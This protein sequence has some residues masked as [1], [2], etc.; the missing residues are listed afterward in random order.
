MP[1]SPVVGKSHTGDFDVQSPSVYSM[2][3]N[4]SSLFSP[5]K[6]LKP[7]PGLKRAL[8]SQNGTP[9]KN[10][11]FRQHSRQNNPL[12]EELQRETAIRNGMKDIAR[13]ERRLL[14]KRNLLGNA[15][16]VKL[17]RIARIERNR[18]LFAGQLSEK[19]AELKKVQT[20]EKEFLPEETSVVVEA[21]II[22]VEHRWTPFSKIVEFDKTNTSKETAPRYQPSLIFLESCNPH[23]WNMDSPFCSSRYRRKIG[24]GPQHFFDELNEE[25]ENKK[26]ITASGDGDT[27]SDNGSISSGIDSSASDSDDDTCTVTSSMMISR[28][29]SLKFVDDMFMVDVK[30]LQKSMSIQE[31]T[32]EGEEDVP[33]NG[34]P[35]EANY[36][37]ENARNNFFGLFNKYVHLNSH[38]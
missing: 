9:S 32:D 18:A 20:R 12:L 27:K 5:A 17:D 13:F 10:D 26:N 34:I 38:N 3:S 1:K 23:L 19:R 36:F 6:N 35:R 37:G 14:P 4:S 24:Y 33:Y 2:G 30:K 16:A 31:E 25:A 29:A 11:E 15:A 7:K 21:E 8:T 22:R 28:S